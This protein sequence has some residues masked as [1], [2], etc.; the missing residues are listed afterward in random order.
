MIRI[1][2]TIAVAVLLAACSTDSNETP[3]EADTTSASGVAGR[4]PGG[5]GRLDANGI[6]T[7][8]FNVTDSTVTLRASNFPTPQ[9]RVV[10]V[11]VTGV[12][13][14]LGDPMGHAD[15]NHLVR[16]FLDSGCIEIISIP[17]DT[18]FDAGFDDTTGL[19]KLT[20]V[21]ANR[22]RSTYLKAVC[23]I[24]GVQRIDYWVEFGFSQAIGLL[25]LMGYKDNSSATLRVLRSR[26][27]YAAGDFQRVY[28]QGQ[29]IRQA[30][31]RAFDQTDN[32]VGELALR[33]ALALVETN[34]TYDAC[35]GILA[36]LRNHGFTSED[37]TRVWVRMRPSMVTSL[38]VYSF[39]STNV[40]EINRQISH[41][42]SK[43][44]LDSIP[45]NQ[46]TYERR[47]VR[48]IDRA[49]ADSAKSPGSVVRLLRRP[50][51][52]RAWLQINDISV[53]RR[54]RD[55]ICGMLSAS[56]RRLKNPDAAK[57]IEDYVD[58]ENKV[59]AGR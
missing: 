18:P 30:I 6:D 20:N 45:I 31:M 38:K 46:E 25:E 21:R 17:R 24:A 19:N 29:F 1:V 2:A 51:E 37:P 58:L 10:N 57:R 49:A 27:A 48:L 8:T 41:K 13:S 50:Y 22:G 23:E 14:R 33:A 7:T 53:R 26:Q 36:E 5:K 12:D 47:L 44:G 34:M 3:H 32:I 39:D 54:Y 4:A 56:Y 28:N 11:M 59:S 42:I 55:R 15:A 40:K 35:D 52:Q 16:F 43:L 9:G